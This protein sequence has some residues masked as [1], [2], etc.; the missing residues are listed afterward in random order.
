MFYPDVYFPV[1]GEQS[2]NYK[3][4]NIIHNINNNQIISIKNNHKLRPKVPTLPVNYPTFPEDLKRMDITDN[5]PQRDQITPRRGKKVSGKPQ[6]QELSVSDELL[7][8]VGKTQNKECD[9]F[10]KIGCYV[11]RV[12]YDWFL[13]NGSCK[14]WK[15]GKPSQYS[16][17]NEAIKRIF[18]GKW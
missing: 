6:I 1:A 5:Q 17:L 3:Q 10:D 13:V 16:G 11:I 9:G 12:Y 18:I 15:T 2:L 14:C 7:N 8:K 4:N